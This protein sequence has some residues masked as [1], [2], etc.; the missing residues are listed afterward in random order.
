MAQTNKHHVHLCAAGSKPVRKDDVK[1]GSL[2]KKKS[3]MI[4]REVTIHPNEN[5][6]RQIVDIN[7]TEYKIFREGRRAR[8]MC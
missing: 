3:R 8:R 2:P 7:M 1:Q 4:Q 6:S 5:I